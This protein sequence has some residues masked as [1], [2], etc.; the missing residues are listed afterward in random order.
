MEERINQLIAKHLAGETTPQEQKFIE[1]WITESDHNLHIYQSVENI[2]KNSKTK[3]KVDNLDQVFNKI[4]EKAESKES[5]PLNISSSTIPPG[6]RIAATVILFL[7]AGFIAF[8]AYKYTRP[9]DEVIADDFTQFVN[10]SVGKGQKLKIHLPD[11]SKVW[12]NSE[13]EISYPERFSDTARNVTFTGE[14]FFEVVSDPKV[15]FII[16]TGALNTSVLGTS[17][18]LRH[19]EE[20]DHI[21]VSLV[22]GSVSVTSDGQIKAHLLKPGENITYHNKE[23]LFTKDT[24]NLKSVTAWKDG[25][26]LFENNTYEEVIHKLERW[27]GVE[28]IMNKNMQPLWQFSAEFQNE[29]LEIV[30]ES[31]SYSK[32]FDYK[33]DQKKVY[34]TF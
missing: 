15:P 34:L 10:K 3:I 5:K 27:Y 24:F 12:L 4:L 23:N 29:Y 1:R 26:L 20:E 16:R 9:E 18:N 17:F 28:F 22:S 21:N 25:I 6:F 2:W 33:I 19:Y 7:A 32:K 8:Y 11:G 13:S 31:I 30:L 14:A